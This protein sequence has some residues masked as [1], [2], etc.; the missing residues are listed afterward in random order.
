MTDESQSDLSAKTLASLFDGR[1]YRG[2][3]S[4]EEELRAKDAGLVVVFGASDDAMEFRGAIDDELGA[5][6]GTTAYLDQA[7][8]LIDNRCDSE[9]CPHYMEAQQQAALKGATIEALWGEHAH[10]SWSYKTAIPHE[11]FTIVE[12]G[13]PYCQG[14][15]FSLADVPV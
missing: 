15:V 11:T 2:E 5:W 13:D 7:K 12:D 10:C 1:E 3:I 9:D 6:E 4:T 14:I 8:G